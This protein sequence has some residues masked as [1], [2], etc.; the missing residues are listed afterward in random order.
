MLCLPLAWLRLP[1]VIALKLAGTSDWAF[2]H[3][4]GEADAG[5]AHRPVRASD[6]YP[7]SSFI[8]LRL[9]D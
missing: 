1:D 3:G 4:P 2:V 9:A 5:K 7:I 6:H 8:E